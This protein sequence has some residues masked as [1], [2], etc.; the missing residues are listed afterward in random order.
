MNELVK[1]AHSLGMEHTVI[2]CD[3]AIYELAYPIR[4]NHPDEF[5][6]V[7]LQLGG[8]HLCHNYMKCITKVI[9]GSG[10]EEIL[11]KAEIVHA[12]TA[13]NI[14]GDKC[15]YYQTLRTLG[16]LYEAMVHLRW[17]AVEEWCILEQKDVNCPN[18]FNDMLPRLYDAGTLSHNDGFILD[19]FLVELQSD[20]IELEKLFKEYICSKSDSPTHI[21]WDAFIEMC[22]TRL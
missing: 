13:N 21:L 16:I 3:Q 17:T 14:F 15:D 9:Q 1:V 10:S 8:F 19:E 2:N 5:S 6:S 20:I 18:N 11:S 4:K 12:G 7:I 22:Q